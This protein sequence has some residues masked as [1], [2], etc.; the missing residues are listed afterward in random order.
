MHF[1]PAR[2]HFGDALSR[3]QLPA[4]YYIT[5]SGRSDGGGA[6]M[7]A[8]YSTILYARCAG[9][10]YL[11]APIVSVEHNA[12]GDPGWPDKW[13]SAFSAGYGELQLASFDLDAVKQVGAAGMMSRVPP[14]PPAEPVLLLASECHWYADAHADF[15]S[16]IQPQIKRRYHRNS[17]P[18]ARPDDRLIVAVHVRRGDVT[19]SD[20]D[21][22]TPNERVAFQIDKLSSALGPLRHEFHVFSE[23]IE[24]DFG[25]IRERAVVHLGG[26]VFECLQSLIGADIFVMAKSSFSY[27]AAL[28]SRG[29]VIYSPFWHAPLRQW[30]MVD[31]D[32]NLP[33][34]HFG[35]ALSR[36]LL[37]R[38]AQNQRGF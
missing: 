31:A 15:Y 20:P 21:R 29:I 36:Y 4:A 25:P 8:I 27:T 26:D 38:F 18:I 22:F 11:H 1:A 33:L 10:V 5:C 2:F 6:Q 12:F 23:G 19:P 9:L 34:A 35:W 24:E 14:S 13:E 3:G 37:L 30:V 17:L 28:L 32:G 7:Q 16:L